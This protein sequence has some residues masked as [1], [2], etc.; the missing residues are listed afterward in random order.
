MLGLIAIAAFPADLEEFNKYLPAGETALDYANA[1]AYYRNVAPKVRSL[2]LERIA[3]L[4]GIEP[5]VVGTK[6]HTNADGTV[7]ETDVFEKDTVYVKRVIAAGW[8]KEQLVPELQAA[9]DTVGWDLSSTRSSGPSKKDTATAEA[10]AQK[11]AAGGTTW[12]RVK[13]YFESNNPNLAVDLDDE[14]GEIDMAILVEA[15]RIDR[16]RRED[17]TSAI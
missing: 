17:I 14:T 4:T 8:T 1:E 3:K 2:L 13:T 9:F 6:Q 10:I 15:C 11:V 5:K 7:T 12:E 16:I